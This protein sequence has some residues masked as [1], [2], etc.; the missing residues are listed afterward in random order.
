[1][2]NLTTSVSYHAL[3]LTILHHERWGI[4]AS[5]QKVTTNLPLVIYEHYTAPIST[6]YLSKKF[7]WTPDILR[8]VA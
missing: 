2:L 5:R 4:I 3:I 1:M 6:A 7:T 8:K